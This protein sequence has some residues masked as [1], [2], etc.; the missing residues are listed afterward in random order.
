ML[1]NEQL[2]N[3]HQKYEEYFPAAFFMAGFMF[4]VFTIGRIDDWFN[5]VMQILYLV[6]I[7]YFLVLEF[8]DFKYESVQNRFLKKIVVFK[9]EIFHFFL[10]TLL[11]AFT[12]FYF[13]SA[14][15][16]NAFIFML[17]M[18]FVLVLNELDFFQKRGIIVKSILFKLCLF[19]FFLYVTPLIFGR[20]GFAMFL[21]SIFLSSFTSFLYGKWLLK[22]KVTAER[23]KNEFIIPHASVLIVFVSLYFFKVIP[24]VPLSIQE[25]GI[26]HN[27]E[28]K[29]GGYL[30]Y[31]EHPRWKFW[32]NGDEDFEAREGD[33]VYVFLR[34][35][36][37]KGFED[38]I[39]LRWQYRSKHGEWLTSD[40]I[41]LRILGGRG[42]GFRGYAYKS[43]YQLGEWR[44]LAET[45]D[46]LEIGR[47]DFDILTPGSSV[48][49]EPVVEKR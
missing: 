20:V 48:V 9:D 8:S 43:N 18:S 23:M 10:G 40:R 1:K 39:Y 35:F 27:I 37:P 4:D 7:A 12:L 17:I 29:D 3:F 25:I 45:E 15:L 34:L 5:I 2:N 44:I 36:A 14:S 21:I 11:S 6:F 16:S 30:L 28:K 49:P 13:K 46:Q 41:E 24:P 31:S 47:I 32:L 33:K 42:A 38:K 19:S 26:Y 22:K